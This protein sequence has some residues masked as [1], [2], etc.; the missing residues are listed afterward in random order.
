M[1]LPRFGGVNEMP[2]LGK[3]VRLPKVI[4]RQSVYALSQR[5][6]GLSESV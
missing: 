2:R 5:P 3:L 1:V 6:M 4:E